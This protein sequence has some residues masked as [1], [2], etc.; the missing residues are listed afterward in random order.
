MSRPVFLLLWRNLG[1]Y[2]V[3]R[4]RAAW[5]RF[6]AEGV[7]LVVAELARRE[8]TRDWKQDRDSLPFP[9]RTL[10]PGIEL[11]ESTPSMVAKLRRVMDELTPAGMAVAGYDRPEMR[12]ALRWCRK[13]GAPSVL[14]SETKM[15]DRHRRWWR[16]QAVRYWCRRVGAAVVSGTAS[17]AYL[18]RMG[19]DPGR[20]FMP[21]GVI[22][23]AFMSETVPVA[24]ATAAPA[25]LASGRY[26]LA[27][28]RLLEERKNLACLVSAYHAY[29]TTAKEDPWSLV[30]CGDGPDR[31]MLEDHV[32][33][34]GVEGVRFE[35]HRDIE[36]LVAY[37]AHA[38]C[39]VHPAAREAWGLVVNEAMAASLPVLVSKACG[40]AIDLVE[41]G[42]NGFT[43]DP[44]DE[45]AL[46]A[47]LA[48]M[49]ATDTHARAVMGERGRLRIQDWSPARFADALW[50]AHEAA[51]RGDA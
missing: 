32:R 3:A 42:S 19:I 41:N 17:R 31:G 27:C 20:V 50:M 38:G 4:S 7:D 39:L 44:H 40:C 24:K 14:M 18:C 49:A 36:S 21:Y 1:P 12:A 5:E 9:L 25:G 30:V 29:R 11:D 33:R 16:R 28:C 2:H 43:F 48:K 15:D 22:D 46:S 13:H 37:Y 34:L 23:N 10:A 45:G 35:G 51:G 47:L 26:F 8:V 6:A